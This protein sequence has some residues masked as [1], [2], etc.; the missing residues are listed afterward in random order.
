MYD[1]SSS[2]FLHNDY[3]V[4]W[5][6]MTGLKTS[7]RKSAKGIVSPSPMTIGFCNWSYMWASCQVF[8]L[9]SCEHKVV[10]TGCKSFFQGH[11]NFKLALNECT[12]V[13]DYLYLTKPLQNISF[14]QSLTF[15]N[16]PM[17]IQYP[18][19]FCLLFFFITC[20]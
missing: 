8:K 3:L 7:N 6:S 16:Q 4:R 10:N 1:P 18:F 19:I 9:W 13:K 17:L 11:Q 5:K 20:T 14:I 15:L 2:Y 12:Q